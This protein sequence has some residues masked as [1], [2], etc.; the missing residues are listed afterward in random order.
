MGLLN[1][2]NAERDLAAVTIV[3][4]VQ[5]GNLPAKRWSSVAAKN[6]N[7][8]PLLVQAGEP[9]EGAIEEWKFKIG[10]HVADF[11]RTGAG[12]APER[13]EGQYHHRRSGDFGHDAAEKLGRLPH[14]QIEPGAGRRIQKDE[15]GKGESQFS[16]QT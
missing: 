3:Q 13:P 14:G 12:V 7:D 15:A 16:R 1:I 8:R 11:E 4:A 10:R 2:Y 5:R 9:D 6:E